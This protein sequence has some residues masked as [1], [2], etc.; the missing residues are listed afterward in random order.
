MSWLA[1]SP[2]RSSAQV[3]SKYTTDY[4]LN[5][6]G[7]EETPAF[8]SASALPERLAHAFKMARL[9]PSDEVLDLG[10]G[11]GEIAI[12][13]AR[14]G[15][16]AIGLDYSPDAVRIARQAAAQTAWASRPTFFLANAD[17]EWPIEGKFDVVFALDVFEHLHASELRR[18]LALVRSRLKPGGRLVFHTSPNRYYYSVAYRAVYGLSR[19]SGRSRLPANSRSTH[20]NEMHIGEL[21]RRGLI[22][23]FREAGLAAELWVFGLERIVGTIDQSGLGTGLRRRLAS[24]ACLPR[25]RTFTN[26]DI[27]GVAALETTTLDRCFMLDTSGEVPLDHPFFFH[28]GCYVP[29]GGS[30]PHRWTSPRW[31]VRGQCGRPVVLRFEVRNWPGRVCRVNMT[32]PG[33]GSGTWTI[34]GIHDEIRVEWPETDRAVTAAFTVTP[35]FHVGGDPRPFG[36]CLEKVVCE[37]A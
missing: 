35:E 34:G 12:E 21:T 7:G 5:V 30:M 37:P 36:V 32:L 25:L 2:A 26:S 13:A 28:G 17:G 6:C 29:V 33:A 19:A 4:Y 16:R 27:A 20:E 10:C 15:C 23:L 11:R 3:R 8:D 22:T 9:E 18:L 14:L 24:W 1:S 31:S